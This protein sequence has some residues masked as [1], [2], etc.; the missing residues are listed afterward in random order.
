MKETL[1]QTTG[2][3]RFCHQIELMNQEI[4]LELLNSTNRC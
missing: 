2:Q 4:V 3:M 1:Q